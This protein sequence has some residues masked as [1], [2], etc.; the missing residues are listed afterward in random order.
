[1]QHPARHRRPPHERRH[2]L[3]AR[4]RSHRARRQPQPA[5]RRPSRQRRP[6]ESPRGGRLAARSDG[7]D[8]DV[9]AVGHP[10]HRRGPDDHRL[11]LAAGR[12][13]G[14]AQ[15]R[16]EHHPAVANGFPPLADRSHIRPI[17]SVPSTPVGDL[18]HMSTV[19]F[20]SSRF[21]TLEIETEEVIEF[22]SGL[23]GLGGARYSLLTTDDQSPFA[24]LQSIDDPELALPIT[25]PWLFFTY[26]AV[27]LHHAQ[28]N[29]I[30][31]Q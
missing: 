12:L 21:G 22:P 15:G 11:Q 25:N 2:R 7:R 17:R 31:L 27:A 26:Y 5:A 14:G 20:E 13:P 8:D 4:D 6:V 18:Q 9:A 19:T 29:R 24:W 28:A 10:G 3:A 30:A 16:G 23:I 1:P